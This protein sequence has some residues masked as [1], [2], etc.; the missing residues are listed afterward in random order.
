MN[1]K[2]GYFAGAAIMASYFLL[3]AG[4][5][6]LSRRCRNRRCGDVHATQVAHHITRFPWLTQPY[7][8]S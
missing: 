1:R 5:P 7:P 4:A 6:P 8:Q 3:N 2:W